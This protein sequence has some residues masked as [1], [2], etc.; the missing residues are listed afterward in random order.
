[1]AGRLVVP[2]LVEQGGGRFFVAIACASR[3]NIILMVFPPP[4]FAW[5]DR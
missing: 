5:D 3:L 2:V 1:M 4:P